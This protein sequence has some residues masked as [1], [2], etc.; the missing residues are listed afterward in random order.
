MSMAA[1]RRLLA[2]VKLMRSYQAANLAMAMEYRAA[3]FA[4]VFGMILNDSLW[5]AY[6]TLFFHRFPVVNGWGRADVLMLWA[7]IATGFGLAEAT[8]GAW[9]MLANY[10]AEGQLDYYLVLPKH[11]L[12]HALMSR[13]SPTGWGDLIFG[14]AVF[15]I[16]GQPSLLRT[17]LFVLCS[18]A[19]GLLLLGI[20]IACNSLAFF[21]GHADALARQVDNAMIHF[22]TYPGAIFDGA[23]RVLLFTLIP[24]G[25]INNLPVTVMREGNLAF[26]A[27]AW[28][29]AC[30]WVVL[31]QWIFELGLRRYESGNLMGPRL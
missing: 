3:F 23:V 19:C 10:I 13:A 24:A 20:S 26:L 21:V 18:L 9:R 28:V 30:G 17:G 25:F 5:L 11:P 14:L 8:F 27:W 31:G 2:H 4:Q 1:N 12:W 6:W 29:A 22:S 15:A 7:I 16:W